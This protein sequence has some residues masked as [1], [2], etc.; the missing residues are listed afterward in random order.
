[1]PGAPLNEIGCFACKI[2]HRQTNTTH[3]VELSVDEYMIFA[4]ISAGCQYQ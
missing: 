2:I 4:E 3:A 1:L